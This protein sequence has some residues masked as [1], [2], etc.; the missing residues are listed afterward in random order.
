[1]SGELPLHVLRRSINLPASIELLNGEVVNGVVVRC[2]GMMN[3][4]MRDAIRTSATGDRFWRASQVFVRGASVAA[5]RLHHAVLE[6]QPTQRGGRGRSGR[7]RGGRPQRGGRGSEAQ[8]DRRGRG[9]SAG[10][11][12]GGRG[13]PRG[14]GRGRPPTVPTGV[15]RR[16]EE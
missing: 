13:N 6:Q 8:S 10:T 5:V 14:R 16:R 12:G 4:V 15:K 7:G 2:D 3:M 11:R 1:M 9:R